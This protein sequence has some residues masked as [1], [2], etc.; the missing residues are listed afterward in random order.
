MAAEGVATGER[1]DAV[2]VGGGPNGLAAALTLARAGHAV[3]VLEAADAVGGGARS[4]ELTLPGYVHDVCS[5]IHPFGR[6]SPFFADAGLEALG[7]SWIDPPVPLGHPLDDGSAV[8]LRRSVDET[9]AELG[10]DGDA[11]RRLFGP[12]VRDWPRL[13][14]DLLAPFHIPLSPARAYTM[15]RFGLL[16]LQPASA[17]ARRFDGVR[18]RALFAG[19]AAHSLIRLGE[20]TSAAAALVMLASAHADGWPMPAGGSGEISRALG[21]AAEAAGVRIQTGRRV[22]AFDGLPPHQVALFDVTPRQLLAIGGDRFSPGYRKALERFRYGPGV[23]KVDIAISAPIPWRSTDLAQAGTVHLGGTFEEIAR[24]EAEINAGRTPERPFVLL[25]QQSLFD[26][27]RAPDGHH[28]VWAY[29]HVPNGS[30][31]DMTET[32]LRQIERFAPGFRETILEISARGPAQLEAYNANNIGGDIG[33]GRNGLGQLFTR[34]AW[35]IDPYTTSDPDVF[36][37]SAS[38]PPGGGV[39]G[40]CGYHAARSAARRLSRSRRV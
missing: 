16:G 6:T 40:M 22:E 7:L 8:L 9:A 35:R 34:P 2:V 10:D 32:I 28:T 21:R 4:A 30:A 3:A 13:M 5:A 33:G 38:T 11:W 1:T 36:L 15:A 20:V 18:A 25:A 19:A 26:P 14:P 39:H 29:C 37:C 24:G 31:A 23:F 12:L 27:G 17:V